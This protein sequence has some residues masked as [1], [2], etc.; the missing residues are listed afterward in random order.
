[1]ISVSCTV[2]FSILY[3][4][5]ISHFLINGSFRHTV[6]LSD[7]CQHFS[8]ALRITNLIL[9][10]IVSLKHGIMAAGVG[11]HHCLTVFEMIFYAAKLEIDM[12]LQFFESGGKGLSSRAVRNL[13]P[14]ICIGQIFPCG[15]KIRL[16]GIIVTPQYLFQCAALRPI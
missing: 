2:F 15:Y 8:K 7:I 16:Y 10:V 5:D 14:Q 6:T 11:F 12:L 13:P 9:H 1:M 3:F 4:M